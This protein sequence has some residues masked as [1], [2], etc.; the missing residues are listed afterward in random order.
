MY[1]NIVPTFDLGEVGGT[2]SKVT[3]TVGAVGVL[4][5][6]LNLPLTRLRRDRRG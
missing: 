5:E 3:E 1:L 2:F 6:I 4:N